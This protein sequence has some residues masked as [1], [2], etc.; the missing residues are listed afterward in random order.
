LFV[1]PY[2][3]VKQKPMLVGWLL[4]LLPVT[5]SWLASESSNGK[6]G[7]RRFFLLT[8]MVLPPAFAFACNVPFLCSIMV[9]YFS[10]LYRKLFYYYTFFCC[11][12]FHKKKESHFQMYIEGCIYCLCCVCV[13]VCVYQGYLPHREKGPFLGKSKREG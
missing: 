1:F 8:L 2:L 3:N 7:R 13:C 12:W 4:L 6:R 10:R 5:C 9:I 11:F